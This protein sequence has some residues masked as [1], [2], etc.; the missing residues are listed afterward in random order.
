MSRMLSDEDIKAIADKLTEYSG[1]SSAEHRDH[2]EALTLFIQERRQKMEDWAKIRQ[3]VSGW[4]IIV[5]L[6]GIG[7]IVYN[8]VIRGE[9]TKQQLER[10]Q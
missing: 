2:H 10:K 7:T 4:L 3:Q 1:L 5:V 8:S 9:S 6:G